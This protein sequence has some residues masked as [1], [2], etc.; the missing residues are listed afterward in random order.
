MSELSSVQIRSEAESLARSRIANY[1]PVLVNAADRQL[2][3][4]GNTVAAVA[5]HIPTPRNKQS[6]QGSVENQ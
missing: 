4:V 6:A 5:L 3:I 2:R 1:S